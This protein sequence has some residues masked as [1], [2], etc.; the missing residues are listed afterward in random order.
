MT[1]LAKRC[2]RL[3]FKMHSRG[4][5]PRSKRVVSGVLRL[6]SSREFE[7]AGPPIR[8]LRRPPTMRARRIASALSGGGMILLLASLLL[9]HRGGH[10]LPWSAYGGG[11]W[12]LGS[13]LG[14]LPHERAPTLPHAA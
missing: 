7:W 2:T 14:M 4:S 12:A 5:W 9:E 1:S 13:L 10:P 11:L 3:M 8:L 6:P